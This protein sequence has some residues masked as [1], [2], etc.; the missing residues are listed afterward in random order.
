MFPMVI[1]GSKATL[2]LLAVYVVA[3][4]SRKLVVRDEV[5]SRRGEGR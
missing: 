2:V 1:I 4:R 3:I 5:V